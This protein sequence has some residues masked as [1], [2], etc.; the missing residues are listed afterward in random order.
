M[1]RKVVCDHRAVPCHPSQ[2]LLHSLSLVLWDFWF[3]WSTLHSH[4][5]SSQ[6][7]S[8][9]L[10][11]ELRR[12]NQG[13]LDVLAPPVNKGLSTTDRMPA[14][15]TWVRAAALA[16]LATHGAAQQC[17]MMCLIAVY[18]PQLINDRLPQWRRGS[19]YREALLIRKRWFGL[20]PRQ[21]GMSR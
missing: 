15:F 8:S 4:F 1:S 7:A 9:P 10:P 6:C 18:E 13:S 20:L 11:H 14:T 16:A 21:V 19:R 17:C 12:F 3:L 2:P 5:F